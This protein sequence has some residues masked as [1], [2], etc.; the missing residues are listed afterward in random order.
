MVGEIRVRNFVLFIKSVIDEKSIAECGSLTTT[1]L[2]IFDGFFF[3]LYVI[4]PNTQ[5]GLNI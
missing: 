5:D 4:K 2:L 3:I 1:L